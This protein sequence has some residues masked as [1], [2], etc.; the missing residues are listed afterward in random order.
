MDKV[1]LHSDLNNFYAS[2]ECAVCPELRGKPLIVAGSKEK[3]HGIVLAKNEIAKSHG[4][5]TGDTIWQ[6]KQKCPALVVVP[7][8]FDLY[9]S[10]SEQIFELYT[11]FT[12]LVEPFGPDECWLDVTG[13]MHLFGD[14]K[15]IA[16]KIRA[17]IKNRFAL[18]A[19]VGVSFNK[20]FAKMGSDIKKPDAT[21]VIDRDNFRSIIWK[22]PVSDM[23]M[24]GKKTA[25]KLDGLNIHT[26][27]DLA[28]ADSGALTKLLGV[29]G[30]SIYKSARGEDTTPVR[31]YHLSR[32]IKSVGHG[33]TAVKDITNEEDARTLILYLSDLIA[34]RM[35]KYG[36]RGC[37]ISVHVRY[38]DLSSES[39]QATM[40]T[41][42]AS[43][44]IAEHALKLYLSIANKPARTITVTIF[45]LTHGDCQQLS[46]FGD[47]VEKAEKLDKAIAAIRAKYGKKSVGLA[48]MIEQD[49]I[50]DKSDAEDFLPFKR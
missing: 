44:I 25:E 45:N 14:G 37:G 40:P 26:V 48:A 22:L 39:K 7:P 5:K 41:T 12:D 3:R 17:E 15:Q 11:E 47:D 33:M 35:R 42:C 28:N 16:D 19:S 36:V 13:S 2:V 10:Y 20:V 27:G 6:A 21:T 30:M 46:F 31:K 29:N 4:I 24:V 32:E 18:T 49:F 9:M 8:H 50:Y 43:S 38:Y 34:A 23:L 1:I